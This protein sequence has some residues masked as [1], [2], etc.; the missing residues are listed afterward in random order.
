[1]V[2]FRPSHTDRWINKSRP[3]PNGTHLAVD[4][5][6]LALPVVSRLH[7]GVLGRCVSKSLARL[8]CV[9]A[10]TRKRQDTQSRSREPRREGGRERARATSCH[11]VVQKVVCRRWPANNKARQG[12]STREHKRRISRR[13]D[14][15]PN[16]YGVTAALPYIRVLHVRVVHLH[17]GQRNLH[18]RPPPCA[19][20]FS[21]VRR[22]Q[23]PL[24]PHPLLPLALQTP[25][26]THS[27]LPTPLCIF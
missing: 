14:V 26:N 20:C 23:I 21:T 3:K 16:E 7:G 1:M 8:R 17:A 25:Q 2:I 24:S 22:K 27:P 11:F 4:L 5:G 19:S 12:G 18:F 15:D 13:E 6:L 9:H 10:L